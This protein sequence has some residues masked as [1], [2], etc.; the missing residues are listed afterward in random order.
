LTANTS[1]PFRLGRINPKIIMN[2]KSLFW[3]PGLVAALLLL[4]VAVPAQF[5]FTTNNGAITITQYTGSGGD[6]VIPDTINGL[7]VAVV[8]SAAFYQISALTSVTFGTNVTTIANNAIF[9]C[10]NIA[11]VSIPASVTNIGTGPVI[12]CKSLASIQVDPAN[13][14]YTN[15]NLA[16]LNTRLTSL[17]EF[18]NGI[19]GGY[20]LPAT[21]TNVGQAFI[22]NSLTSITVSPANTYFTNLAGVLTD[23]SRTY[24][25]SYPGGVAGSYVV[26]SNVT[27]IVSAAFEYSTGVTNVAI[28]TNVNSVGLFAFYDCPNLIAIS[29]NPTNAFFSSSNGVLFDKNKITLIQFPIAVGGS[30]QVPNSVLHIGEGVFGDDFGLTSIAIANSVTNIDQQAFYG[31]LNLASVSL[32]ENLKTIGANAFFYCE[33]LTDLA[34]PAGLSSIG[35]YAFG[36]CQSLSSVCFAGN[37]PTDGGSIFYFDNALSTILYLNGT[38]GWGASYDGIPTAPCSVC[39]NSSPQ[40]FIAQSGINVILTWSATGFGLQSTTNLTSPV[41]TLVYGQNSVT[42]PISGA[43]M[44]YRLSQ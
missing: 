29:V 21:V 32:G 11:S 27:T 33:A 13:S 7:K 43:K 14:F 31:C 6:V 38:S 37:Q 36:G 42:N 28:G 16:L 12:D 40:L 15:V 26:P 18:P 17:I 8:G 24:L 2:S 1:V 30:Y 19:G 4:P 9:Q 20:V 34:F 10:P 25:V 3:L 35:Q 23:K 41:W 5:L 22:G 39:G 44:F